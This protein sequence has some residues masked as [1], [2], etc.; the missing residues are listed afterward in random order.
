MH[1]SER[2]KSTWFSYTATCRPCRQL[3]KRVAFNGALCRALG[4]RAS[5]SHGLPAASCRR[6]EAFRACF[7]LWQARLALYEAQKKAQLPRSRRSAALPRGQYSAKVGV[8]GSAYALPNPFY[9]VEE[10]SR[11]GLRPPRGTFT[12]LG[13]CARCALLS[14]TRMQGTCEARRAEWFERRRFEHRHGL[15]TWHARRHGR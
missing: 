9:Y 4:A 14:A 1:G 6:G 8:V 7:G 15:R 2:V 13:T 3:R 5:T 10:G 11:R 12:A